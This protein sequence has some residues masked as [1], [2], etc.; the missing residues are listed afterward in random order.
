MSLLGQTNGGW[1]QSSS[2]LRVLYMGTPNSIGV[3]TDD[4]F[5]QTNPP[6]V[7]TSATITAQVNTQTFGVLSGSVAFARGDKGNNYIGGP[8][9]V[10]TAKV[11]VVGVFLNSAGGAPYENTPAIASGKCPYVS[12]QGSYGNT[13]FEDKVLT[14][15]NAGNPLTALN[16]ADSLY[17]SRNG[18]LTNAVT[19]DFDA[20]ESEQLWEG[21]AAASTVIGIVTNVPDSAQADLVYNQRI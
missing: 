6:I 3:L 19:A 8:A 21:T 13:L 12:G 20:D 5:T 17:A 1:V 18:F 15:A 16:V 7:T 11:A 9:A 2:T 10:G 4:A 14:G